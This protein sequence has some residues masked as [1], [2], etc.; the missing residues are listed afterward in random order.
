MMNATLSTPKTLD[1][2]GVSRILAG[3]LCMIEP[4]D[5]CNVD[6]PGSAIAAIFTQE[7]KELNKYVAAKADDAYP[8]LLLSYGVT[9]GIS[10]ALA[11]MESPP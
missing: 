4:K 11:T 1:S 6:E 5:G 8:G 9:F 10:A 7:A 3:Y 2:S